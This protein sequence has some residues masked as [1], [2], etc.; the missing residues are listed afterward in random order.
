MG[1]GAFAR[2]LKAEV[3]K[4]RTVRSTFVLLAVA[5]V[6]TIGFGLLVAYAPR[7]R[8]GLASVLI[9][10]HG[11]ARWFLDS[12]GIFGSIALPLSLI[13]GVLMVTGEY[14]YKTVTS[15]FLAE[16][17]RTRVIGSKL[18]VSLFA[19][20]AVGVSAA[21]G[22]LVLGFILVAA[23]TGSASTMLGQYRS[24]LGYLAAAALYAVYGAGIGA[25]VKN[26]VFA[27]VAGLGVDLV[28]LPIL[29]ATVPGFARW[30]PA[31]AAQALASATQR[32]GFAGPNV[33]LLP[34]WGGVGI[35]LAWGVVL[36]GVGA[37]TAVK[38][39]VT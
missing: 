29:M 15:T 11:S 6:L 13:I 8:R 17:R 26:Q 28:V 36:A 35:L 39:D 1:A 23:S 31:E 12:L 3:D 7:R 38:A 34:W 18:V 33:N 2:S 4:L 25:L 10:P 16:P 9:P 20:L 19:G 30:M 21:A 14:R 22:A 37:Q 24:V 5:F 32:T 27:L